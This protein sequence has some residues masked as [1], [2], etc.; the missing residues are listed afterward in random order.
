MSEVCIRLENI[1]KYYGSNYIVKNLNLD[2]YN[3]EFLTLLG[4]SGCGKTT[5]LR[6]L[7]GFEEP[8]KGTIFLK[9]EDVTYFP[10]YKRD[11]NTVFQNYALFPHL[12][13][14]ENIAFGLKRKG[15]AKDEMTTRVN[16]VLQMVQ[17]ESFAK[18]KPKEMSGG[19][20]QRVAVARAI[21]NNP[22]VLLLDEPLGAL[23]LKLRKQMQLELKHLQQSLGMT[24]L[25]VTHDQEEALTMS[26]RIAV[27]YGGQ[28]EQID[29]PEGI[30]HRPH[31]TFVADFIGETNLLSGIV[32]EKIGEQTVV[33]LFD[34]SIEA[35]AKENNH[36]GEEVTL[37]IRPEYLQLSADDGA[38]GFHGIIKEYIFIGSG[39]KAILTVGEKEIVVYVDCIQYSVGARVF[40]RF[41]QAPVLVGR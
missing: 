7:A 26:D 25:Y 13:I 8:S 15:I 17:M 6:M 36:I 11:V 20:Q 29:T 18:R 23:D 30:Y 14:W 34:G 37:S 16:K 4:P 33:S 3:G 22:T 32:K 19:Q 2:I 39:F 9:G 38:K 41:K 35:K 28:I 1:D 40:V 27:M 10:P 5:T 21:V 31:T 12:N 24:F